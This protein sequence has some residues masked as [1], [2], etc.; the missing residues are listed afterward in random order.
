MFITLRN[1]LA[2]GL[3][4]KG[5]VI[6]PMKVPIGWVD[7][8][9]KRCGIEIFDG[10]YESCFERLSSYPFRKIKILNCDGCESVE[11]FA[12]KLGIKV[13]VRGRRFAEMNLEAKT[14]TDAIAY[15]YI[16]REV[17]DEHIDYAPLAALLPELKTYG[18]ATSYS[19]SKLK[20][21]FFT[22]LSREGYGIAKEVI[23]ERVEMHENKLRRM[24]GGVAYIVALGV[25]NSLSLRSIEAPRDLDLKSMLS[26]MR[27]TEIPHIAAEHPK[28]MLAEFLV[29]TALNGHAVRI[30]ESL[31][32][33]GLAA[34]LQTFS[35][36]GEP[37]C[38]EYRFAREAVE[39]LM[40]FGFAEVDRKTM[41]EFLAAYYPLFS[42][43]VYPVMRYCGDEL[44]RAEKAGVCEIRGT[45]IELKR[46]FEDYARVRLAMVVDRIRESLF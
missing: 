30:A 46:G 36:Y 27:K 4:R 7:V 9:F 25:S 39:A 37:V 42:R 15:L 13:E 44:R 1:A 17:C 3:R 23:A 24:S 43:D 18:L 33:M 35:P 22:S 40:K 14:I 6:S 28:T 19:T 45:R 38:H 2:A 8:S 21:V 5:R 20:P 12:S 31:V 41:A 26:F 29:A 32:R 34:K 10:C 11:E 16:V